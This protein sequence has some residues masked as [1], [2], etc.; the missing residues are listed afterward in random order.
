MKKY[1]AAALWVLLNYPSVTTFTLITV[2][3]SVVNFVYHDCY[4]FI[5]ASFSVEFFYA[6][7]ILLAY[8]DDDIGTER[9][10]RGTDIIMCLLAILFTCLWGNISGNNSLIMTQL[11]IFY[12]PILWTAYYVLGFVLFCVLAPFMRLCFFVKD[13]VN[14][15]S[16]NM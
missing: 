10:K 1:F 7:Y 16:K 9:F 5:L 11:M 14:E 6:A 15:Y 13:W 4:E 12:V 8:N 3:S 2:I